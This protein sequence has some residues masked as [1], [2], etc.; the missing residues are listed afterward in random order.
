MDDGMSKAMNLVVYQSMI[1]G[2]LYAAVGARPD[3]SHAL[4]VVSKFS[5]KPAEAHLTTIKRIYHY[6]K[7]S[8]D[9][10]LSKVQKVWMSTANWVH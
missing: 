4:G 1:G 5:S 2:L 9:V 10:T 6:L 3:I 8:L 7:G